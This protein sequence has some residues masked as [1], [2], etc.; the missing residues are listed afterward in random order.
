MR[1]PLNRGA[2]KI[3]MKHATSAPA[4]LGGETHNFPRNPFPLCICIYE[5]IYIYI[6]AYICTYIYGPSAGAEV[7]P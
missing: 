3:P 4:E 5:Y 2:L 7:A 6:Y 1:G